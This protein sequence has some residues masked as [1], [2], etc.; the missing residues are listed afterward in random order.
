ML[1]FP[2]TGSALGRAEPAGAQLLAAVSLVTML[3]ACGGAPAERSRDPVRVQIRSDFT[4]VAEGPCSKLSVQA[5]GDR[6]LLVYG[7]TGY[8][9]R[10]WLPGDE[11]AAAQSFVELHGDQAMRNHSL[12]RGLSADAGGYVHGDLTF[13]GTFERQAWLLVGTTRYA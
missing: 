1:G 8:D 2:S 12:L 5:V 13:G 3:C 4:V 9:L 7:D 10:G 6:R 11:L